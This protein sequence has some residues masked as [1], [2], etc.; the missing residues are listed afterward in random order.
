MWTS[1][2]KIIGWF[3]LKKWGPNWKKWRRRFA[4]NV[5]V[6]T[7][8]RSMGSAARR[9]NWPFFSHVVSHQN[10]QIKT[11]QHCRKNHGKRREIGGLFFGLVF[12]C[13]CIFWNHQDGIW[14]LNGECTEAKGLENF[15]AFVGVFWWLF[16]NVF[17][18][19][20]MH[21]KNIPTDRYSLTHFVAFFFVLNQKRNLAA[22]Q[23]WQRS[24]K[25]PF[26]VNFLLF[27][28]GGVPKSALGTPSEATSGAVFFRDEAGSYGPK[29]SK[30]RVQAPKVKY[31]Y[32]KKKNMSY[33]VGKFKAV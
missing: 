8:A 31:S 6:A 17:D 5:S 30:M 3:Q 13:L 29:W 11:L 22:K 20:T 12:V 25:D 2:Q 14:H 10:H 15:G 27:T 21:L 26:L 33:F 16:L 24:W 19:A 1:D 32:T 28:V 18:V 7:L 4:T 9:F 23:I